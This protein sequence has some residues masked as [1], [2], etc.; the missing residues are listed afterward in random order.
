MLTGAEIKK[1]LFELSDQFKWHMDRKEYAQ[2]KYC[3]D[4]ALTVSMFIQL[5]PEKR[6]KLFGS[7]QEDKPVEGL[8]REEDVLKATEEC[9]RA[10]QKEQDEVKADLLARYGTTR[11]KLGGHRLASGQ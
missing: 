3:Y 6:L 10:Q 1:E 11:P 2:A 7:R 9:F 8:F 4:T 5:E